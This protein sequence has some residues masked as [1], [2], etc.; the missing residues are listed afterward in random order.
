MTTPGYLT[1]EL[2]KT[3]T[4]STPAI[5]I[6]MIEPEHFLCQSNMENPIEGEETEW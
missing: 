4:Y 3:P 2:Q 6:I 1:K 5:N